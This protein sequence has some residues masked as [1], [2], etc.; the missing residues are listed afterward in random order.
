[1]YV[2]DGIMAAALIEYKILYW[3]CSEYEPTTS[4][5]LSCKSKPSEVVY[6]SINGHEITNTI[7]N[8]ITESLKNMMENLY[9]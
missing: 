9:V 6:Q 1:M 5:K 2:P 3:L 4:T 7:L 8:R